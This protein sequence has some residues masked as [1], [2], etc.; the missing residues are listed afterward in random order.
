MVVVI[1]TELLLCKVAKA[2]KT[3]VVSIRIPRGQDHLRDRHTRPDR[4]GAV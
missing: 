4:R 2:D 1:D 3:D